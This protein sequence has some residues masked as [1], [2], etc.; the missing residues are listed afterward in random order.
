[1]QQNKEKTKELDQK[2]FDG[3]FAGGFVGEST[4]LFFTVN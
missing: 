4:I 3:E 2:Y 1:M